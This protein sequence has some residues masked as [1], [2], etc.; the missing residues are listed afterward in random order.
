[1]PSRIKAITTSSYAAGTAVSSEVASSSP[2]GTLKIFSGTLAH[3][4]IQVSTITFTATIAA[5][6]VTA[7]DNGSGT[8]TGTGVTGTINYTTGI[9]DLTY[10]TAPDNSTNI[11][12]NYTYVVAS[13]T[14]VTAESTGLSGAANVTKFRG[15]LAQGKIVPGTVTF[16]INFLSTQ[17]SITDNKNRELIHQKV[18]DGYINYTDGTF[19][20]FFIQPPDTSAALTCDYKHRNSTYNDFYVK[21]NQEY[22]N[23]ISLYNATGG[24]IVVR[25]MESDDDLTY[26]ES[27]TVTV[28]SG[29][30]K[31]ATI[32]P[33]K[34]IRLLSWNN[35]G[36]TVEFYYIQQ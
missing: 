5:S 9:W 30:Y 15:K 12:V 10:T 21:S 22:Y 29:S 25:I 17:I 34:Y 4:S 3:G 19:L 32:N 6:P 31:T 7:T 11:T 16:K 33:V 1:M 27:S 36:L 13:P 28:S 20:L 35:A 2:N 8:L 14:Q 18:A 23:L 24:S 26:V